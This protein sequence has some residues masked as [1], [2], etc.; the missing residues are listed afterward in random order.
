M[1]YL[2]LNLQIIS[3]A[4]RPSSGPSSVVVIPQ[5]SRGGPT[6]GHDFRGDLAPFYNK[7]IIDGYSAI[8]QDRE[9]KLYFDG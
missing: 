2:I 5:T 7:Q 8:D 4:G 6:S 3:S 1:L 9:G